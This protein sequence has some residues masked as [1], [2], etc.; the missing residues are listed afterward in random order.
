MA[1]TYKLGLCDNR[2]EIKD[3]TTYLFSEGDISFPIDPKILRNQ[4]VDR[5]NELGI[6][7]GD[8][9]V[10]YVTGLTPALTAVI[11]IAFERTSY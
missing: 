4:V 8:D 3:V 10:I 7:D 6:T 11:R 5:F 2:H 9:L 1:T